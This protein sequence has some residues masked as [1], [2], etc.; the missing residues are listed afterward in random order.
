MLWLSQVFQRWIKA[1]SSLRSPLTKLSPS[2]DKA[3]RSGRTAGRMSSR[4]SPRLLRGHHGAI[5][6]SSQAQMTKAVIKY[7]AQAAQFTAE[8]NPGTQR[9][10]PSHTLPPSAYASNASFS[11]LRIIATLVKFGFAAGAQPLLPPRDHVLVLRPFGGASIIASSGKTNVSY[12][13]GTQVGRKPGR[14]GA[15]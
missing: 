2:N 8:L 15:T 13:S 4:L 6:S 5:I 10:P 7:I 1:R 3:G 11:L 14:G 9:S 12:G